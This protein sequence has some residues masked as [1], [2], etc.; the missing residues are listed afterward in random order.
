MCLPYSLK[1]KP[2]DGQKL[3]DSAK[4]EQAVGLSFGMMKISFAITILFFSRVK[5]M[6]MKAKIKEV[7]DRAG[8]GVV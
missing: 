2:L 6:E 7:A 3:P 1:L 5:I 8:A 4:L